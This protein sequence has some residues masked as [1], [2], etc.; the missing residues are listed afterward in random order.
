MYFP[1]D[2]EMQHWTYFIRTLVVLSSRIIGSEDENEK[3]GQQARE[4]EEQE[5][6]GL[7]RR[8]T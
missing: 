4:E 8:P 7:P 6:Q 5:T 1:T 2:N 3:G